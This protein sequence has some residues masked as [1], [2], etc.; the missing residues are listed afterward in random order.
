[1]NGGGSY[2]GKDIVRDE[3]FSWW[4]HQIGENIQNSNKLIREKVILDNKT[5]KCYEKTYHYIKS[6]TITMNIDQPFAVLYP[7]SFVQ[8]KSIKIAGDILQRLPIS[9]E[10][11]N[12]IDIDS[13]TGMIASQV[14][15]TADSVTV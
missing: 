13:S 15:P 6:S 8:G 9:T 1:M 10:E 3:I 2:G 4:T 14:T 7:G 5:H 12:L 11:R